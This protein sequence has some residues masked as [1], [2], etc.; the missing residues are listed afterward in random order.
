VADASLIP[1]SL[2]VNPQGTIMALSQIAAER[3]AV[4]LRGAKAA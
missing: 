3:I 2:G 4:P 1:T